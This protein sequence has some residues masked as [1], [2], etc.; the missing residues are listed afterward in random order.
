MLQGTRNSFSC[1]GEWYGANKDARLLH[2]SGRLD[3][4]SRRNFGQNREVAESKI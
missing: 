1:D 4:V 2:V 3:M